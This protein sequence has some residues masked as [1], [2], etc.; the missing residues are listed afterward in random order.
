MAN[1]RIACVQMDVAIGDVAANRQQIIERLPHFAFDGTTEK[2]VEDYNDGATPKPVVLTVQLKGLKEKVA[3]GLYKWFHLLVLEGEP[4]RAE[5]EGQEGPAH[6][7]IVADMKSRSI[8][9]LE[10]EIFNL[11]QAHRFV[12]R[13]RPRQ[14]A[15]PLRRPGARQLRR[16][17]FQLGRISQE[18]AYSRQLT[19]CGRCAETFGAALGQERAQ[20][21][22]GQVQKLG[23]SDSLAAVLSK[24]LDKAVRGRDIRPHRVRRAPSVMLQM[25]GPADGQRRR[26][27]IA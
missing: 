4:H 20:I 23:L 24:E 8:T 15:G 1:T 10:E 5:P 14:S 7:V 19:R 9:G 25:P 13:R 2:L 18:R 26:R 21:D 11:G 22:C 3:N 17:A 27:M 6:F 12:R 16:L